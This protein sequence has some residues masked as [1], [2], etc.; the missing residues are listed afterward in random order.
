MSINSLDDSGKVALTLSEAA[1][2]LNCDPRTVSR[3]IAKGSI[4]SIT[5]GRRK[6]IPMASFK[7][8]LGIEF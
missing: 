6:L 8:L 7:K 5:I 4:P 1:K 3:A 2:L